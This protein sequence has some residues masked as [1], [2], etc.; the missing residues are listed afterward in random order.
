MAAGHQRGLMVPVREED[1]FRDLGGRPVASGAGAVPKLKKVGGEVRHLQRFISNLIPA[2]AYQDRIEGDDRLLPY[3]GQLTL[4]EQGEDEIWLVDSGGFVSCFNLFRLPPCWHKYMAF[5]KN[6]DARVFGGAPG[7][8]VYAAM[9]VLPMGW[10]SSVPVIQAIVRSLVFGLS[11]VPVSS[12]VAKTKAIPAEDD[13]TVIYLD[14]FDE[15]RRLDSSCRE[16]LEGKAS[17]RHERFLETCRQKGLWQP[18]MK[19]CKVVN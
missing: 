14:S 9:A 7:A 6:V 19:L 17:D 15:L 5:E 13:L 8:Q 2:N 10:I 11:A 16:V 18:R 4:L 12:E 1:V 3:L